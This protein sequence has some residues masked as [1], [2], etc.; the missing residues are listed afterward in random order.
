MTCGGWR[1]SVC[2]LVG[3]L[4][5]GA[6]CRADV[7]PNSGIDFVRIGAVGNA[8]YVSGNPNDF[9]NGRGGVS[10][11][12]SIGRLE[13]TTAQW[14]EFFNA[15]FDRPANDRLPYL[16][17]PD[18]WGAAGATPNTPGGQRWS[19]P[20]G[21]EMN[22]VGDISWRM[23]AMY[24]NWLCNGKSTA[25]SAFMNGAYDAS[26]FANLLTEQT[27]HTPG[28]PYWLP[29]FDEAIK[30]AHFD[31]KRNGTG[32]GGWWAY[33]ITSD[34]APRYG[35]PGAQVSGGLAQANAGY[36][37]PSPYGTLLG[38][39]PTVQ[40]PWGLLDVA[41]GTTEWTET[42]HRL[43]HLAE[44]RQQSVGFCESEK[45][46]GHRNGN[47][48]GLGRLGVNQKLVTAT[49]SAASTVR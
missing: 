17:P 11:E 35:P 36:F 44:L 28:A 3:G 37:S 43:Q 41:G 18:H 47:A 10:Y 20:A 9:V 15:A 32:Q 26:T 19:V 21:R 31:P 4:L 48:P 22:P 14:V 24:C 30:A 13:V 46:L 40:S 7:D 27:T 5:G 49:G 45:A 34:T 1:T 6:A 33:N 29:T 12:Y 23:A 25:R 2:V 8:A 16:I 38:A 42:V 39:Y